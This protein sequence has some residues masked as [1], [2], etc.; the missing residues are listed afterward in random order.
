M[1]NLS[2]RSMRNE[3]NLSSGSSTSHTTEINE[4][5]QATEN[6]TSENLLVSVLNSATSIVKDVTRKEEK[7]D[8]CQK[9]LE[10]YTTS[11]SSDMQ[12]NDINI[13]NSTNTYDIHP[14]SMKNID[15]VTESTREKIQSGKYVNLACLLIPEY[16]HVSDERK[17]E[18]QRDIRLNRS[19]TI[20][21]FILAFNK[22]K[23]IHC[24]RHAWRK[25]ELDAYELIIIEISSVYGPKFYECHKMFAQKCAAALAI[26]K[27][28]N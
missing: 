25:P 1:A 3:E 27:K 13:A 6:N 26:G 12:G 7:E 2:H 17:H 23:R 20:E 24:A 15:Y 21:E 28:I 19:L 10:Q 16:E 18:K 9:T 8:I 14:E 5:I 11:G 22:Y 4:N